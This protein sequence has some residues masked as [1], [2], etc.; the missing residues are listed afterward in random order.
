MGKPGNHPSLEIE[1]GSPLACSSLADWGR[2]H[3]GCMP[4]I[5]A[6][7]ACSDGVEW[8]PDNEVWRMTS[9]SAQDCFPPLYASVTIENGRVNEVKIDVAKTLKS[10]QQTAT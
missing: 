6:Q 7:G 2:I 10:L 8:N 5:Q 9:K 3:A 1:A 4:P